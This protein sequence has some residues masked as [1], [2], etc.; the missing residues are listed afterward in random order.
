MTAVLALVAAMAFFACS[1][2][3]GETPDVGSPND[4]GEMED[5]DAGDPPSGDADT[6]SD[7]DLD[8]GDD[9]STS[10][11]TSSPDE[12]TSQQDA[13][14]DTGDPDEDTGG[15]DDDA[16]TP[17]E[18]VGTPE[19]GECGGDYWDDDHDGSNPWE[20]FDIDCEELAASWD[21]QATE[22]EELI[23]EM[24]NEARQEEQ[25]CGSTSYGPSE[26]LE[27]DPQLR[28]AARIHSWDQDGR[29][30][31]DHD[32]PEGL[33]P[34]GRVSI[35]P[36]PHSSAAEN[37]YDWWNTP[38]N[39]FQGWMDSSGHCRNMMCG[40][41]NQVGIGKYNGKHTLKIIGPGTCW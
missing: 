11:D 25:E 2:P 34:S 16:G 27:M 21:C 35:V 32:T 26:P 9:A 24:I 20:D 37:I 5:A 14:E 29:N 12:D 33:G 23:L 31:Y 18:D 28:C 17:D 22:D 40:S 39:I 41:Y 38:E 36:G 19:P 10:E 8:A 7:T 30:Y 4:A 6:D 15:S 13:G 3:P 1:D